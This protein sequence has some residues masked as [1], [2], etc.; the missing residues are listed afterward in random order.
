MRTS[1]SFCTATSPPHARQ[2]PVFGGLCAR[3]A[4][5]D[6][7]VA[8]QRFDLLGHAVGLGQPLQDVRP[9][10]RHVVE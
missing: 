9:T 3:S 1:A 5:P 8:Q 2:R 6:E 10:A 7:R 4:N